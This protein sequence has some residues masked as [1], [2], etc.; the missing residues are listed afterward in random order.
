MAGPNHPL[1]RLH[2]M[3]RDEQRVMGHLGIGD[4]P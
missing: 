2:D 4:E 1:V 3:N